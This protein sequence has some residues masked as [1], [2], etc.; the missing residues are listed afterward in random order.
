M[1]SWKILALLII[2]AAFTGCATI[3]RPL[4]GDYPGIPPQAV[5]DN[6]SVGVP[7]RWG[8]TIIATHTEQNKTCIEILSRELNSSARPIFD[9]NTEGRFIACKN[10]FQDPQIF[11]EGRE[12]TITGRVD[13]VEQRKVGEYEYRYP[14]VS[15]DV[16]YLWPERFSGDGYG[17]GYGYGYGFSPYYAYYSPFYHPFSYRYGFHGFGHPFGFHSSFFFGSRFGF[18]HR[19]GFRH[20]FGH[21]FRRGFHGGRRGFRGRGFRTGNR[22]GFRGGRGGGGNRSGRVS[23]GGRAA[24]GAG[25][26]SGGART[27]RQ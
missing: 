26:R 20:G 1:Q 8:G 15:T 19:F 5:A 13:N 21:G 14:V 11:S 10:G 12:V 7:V 27:Q 23:R 16:L 4:A 22:G 2:S 6:G 24:S 9:D 3:P 18:G 17:G 25:R